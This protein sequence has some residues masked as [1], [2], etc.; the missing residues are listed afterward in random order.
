[1]KKYILLLISF[2]CLAPCTLLAQ[3]DIQQT[4]YMFNELSFNPAYA[5]AT[6][7]IRGTLLARKQWVGFEGSPFTQTLA[8]DAATKRM[9]SWGFFAINDMLGFQHFVHAKALYSYSVKFSEK[10]IWTPGLGG[11]IIYSSLDGASLE[12]QN[13]EITDPEGIFDLQRDIR[14][15]ID[16]GMQLLTG[17]LSLGL[18]V[19]HV[20][21]SLRYATLA[22][23]PQ[24]FYFYG[25]YKWN[26]NSNLYAVPTIWVKNGSNKTQADANMNFY[27]N[28]RFWLGGT[29][30]I[31]EAAAFLAGIILKE[32]W[33]VG[34]SYDF[35]IS[36][37]TGYSWGNH[38]IFISFRLKPAPPQSG[39][40]QST[41][42]FN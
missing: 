12:Y 24:H 8:F 10:T 31:N 39:F 35:P 11:G 36:D 13:K 5:G 7:T 28:N 32:Q 30:R 23:H 41:R 1:M 38:E 37:L 29:Y 3:N 18:S 16:V 2:A 17:N 40:Y 34:Y 25:Q 27:I 33:Y 19:T 6:G 15:T 21:Q 22:D 26:I 9:G 4:N 20:Q 14:P 42:L